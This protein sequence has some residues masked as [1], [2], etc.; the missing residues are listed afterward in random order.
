MDILIFALIVVLIVGLCIYGI[1]LI[2]MDPRLKIAAKILLIVIAI[3]LL[4]NRAGLA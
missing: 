4:V 3:V 2:P 1:D